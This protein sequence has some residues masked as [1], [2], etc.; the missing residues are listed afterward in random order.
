MNAILVNF[1]GLVP[2]DKSRRSPATR[3][4]RNFSL[5][6]FVL[7]FDGL[8][9]DFTGG[10]IPATVCEHLRGDLLAEV[11][12]HALELIARVNRGRLLWFGLWV[13]HDLSFHG[14]YFGRHFI[15]SRGFFLDYGFCVCFRR[16]LGFDGRGVSVS[17]AGAGVSCTADSSTGGLA[18]SA[19]STCVSAI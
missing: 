2:Y 12:A 16:G 13:F 4:G 14:R 7:R 9:I 17:T 5:Q 15:R 19:A 3:Q 11:G 1:C 10:I 8:V 6:G 18:A